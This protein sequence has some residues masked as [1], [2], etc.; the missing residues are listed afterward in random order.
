MISYKPSFFV[1]A[2]LADL[3]DVLQ[4][5][6]AERILIVCDAAAYT[7]SGAASQL[8]SWLGERQ[9]AYFS[10]FEINPKTHDVERGIQTL[11]RFQPDAI[12]ALGGGTAIDLAKLIA[13]L[14]SQRTEIGALIAGD[15]PLEPSRIPVIAI[16]TTAGTGSEATHFAVVYRDGEKCS[17]A[18][19]SWLP[20]YVLLD[21]A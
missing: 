21:P 7:A 2:A 5:L 16:P 19:P 15:I 3:G 1:M 17:V 13:G 20:K 14:A 9:I 10:G 18:H 8:S 12:V 4:R 6:A 11:E